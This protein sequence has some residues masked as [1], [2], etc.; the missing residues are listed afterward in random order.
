MDI[1]N[2]NSV[3]C[4]LPR[5]AHIMCTE[6]GRL[7]ISGQTGCIR[8]FNLIRSTRA[9]TKCVFVDEDTLSRVL[10]EYLLDHNGSVVQ[11]VN[12]IVWENTKSTTQCQD[13]LSKEPHL[14]YAPLNRWAGKCFL[15]HPDLKAGESYPVEFTEVNIFNRITGCHRYV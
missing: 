4:D 2:N 13:F 12:P 8:R 9:P 1:P 11:V 3:L 14:L 7:D 6:D 5:C 10:D 15:Y